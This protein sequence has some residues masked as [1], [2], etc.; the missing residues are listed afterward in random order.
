MKETLE[1]NKGM[2]K[3][4][5]GC[6][7]TA[8][9][10]MESVIWEERPAWWLKVWLYILLNVNHKDN[11][12][13]KRGENFFTYGKIYQ[14]CH[15]SG[16]GLSLKAPQKVILGLKK[17]LQV[18]TQK[19]TRGMVIKVLNYD[20]YQNLLNYKSIP[21]G[22]TEGD[23]EGDAKVT[24]KRQK[25]YTINKNGPYNN[26]KNKDLID[27][28]F[29]FWN[30]KHIQ[31]HGKIER[32][33]GHINAALGTYSVEE[34]NKAIENYAVIL[35]SDE[36]R[37]DYRWTLDQFLVRGLDRFLEINNPLENFRIKK[38]PEEKAEISIYQDL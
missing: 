23:T 15:L 3:I 28:I 19:T 21:K 38:K 18:V 20:L 26:V 8:R 6:I 1:G 22:D 29:K 27:A 4:P 13:F 2:V 7:L 25:G 31:V 36:Y 37:W 16:E 9:K 10:I 11:K 35:K 32:F 24:Q 30:S 34:I 12:Q 17:A 33:K 5:N 14:D